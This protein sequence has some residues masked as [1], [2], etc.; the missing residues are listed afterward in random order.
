M[1]WITAGRRLYIYMEIPQM[2]L[3]GGRTILLLRE[4]EN[5]VSS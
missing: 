3:K 1:T 4:A 5:N 2:N